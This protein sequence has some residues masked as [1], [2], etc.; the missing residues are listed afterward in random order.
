MMR[1]TIPVAALGQLLL[2]GCSDS[3]ESNDST[4]QLD[5]EV[6]QFE[7]GASMDPPREGVE[8]CV[9]DTSNCATSDA[10]TKASLHSRSWWHRWM[11]Q[12]T[13]SRA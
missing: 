5:H 3:S 10:E 11:R 2:W 9:A 8:V 6:I 13:G 1:R 7:P 12:R 4:L